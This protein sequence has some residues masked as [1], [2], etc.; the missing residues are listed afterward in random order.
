MQGIK[1]NNLSKGYSV[2]LVIFLGLLSAFGPFITDMYLPTMPSMAEVFHTVPAKIQLGLTTS[3]LGLAVGQVFFGPLSDKYG[4]KCVV[5]GSLAIF[6]VST[7]ACIFSES[8]NFFNFCRFLQGLGGAGGIVISRSIATDHYTGRDLAS[9]MA[10]IGAINGIM[11]VIA[12]VTGGMVAEAIGWQ[13]IFV[14]LFC[15]GIVLLAM[16]LPLKESLPLNLRHQGRIIS[17]FNAYGILLKNKV[18]IYSVL[19]YSFTYGILFSYISSSTFIVQEHFHFSEFYFSLTFGANA[20]GMAAGSASVMKLK[21]LNNGGMIGTMG[22]MLVSLVQIFF[23][24]VWDTFLTYEIL[25]FVIAYLLGFIFTSVS[26][27]G[28]DVGRSHSGTAS[29]ILGT[30]GYL[31]GALVSPLVGMGNIMISYI[32]II[33]ICSSLGCYFA[34]RVRKYYTF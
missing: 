6:S 12:P 26:A 9:I 4:R 1:N 22:I 11:P 20:I 5:A 14:V 15:V 17:L 23:Y 29:A 2:Y 8:I 3:L 25:T 34:C 31:F 18:F 28:M 10:I 32:A 33:F 30:C 21:N 19:I 27:M 13:G 24:F 16:N 7:A